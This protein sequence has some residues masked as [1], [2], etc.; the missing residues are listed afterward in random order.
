MLT[1]VNLLSSKLLL[2]ECLL[3]VFGFILVV[4]LYESKI[5]LCKGV[6]L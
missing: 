5:L 4:V 1:N 6:R 2:V 3:S